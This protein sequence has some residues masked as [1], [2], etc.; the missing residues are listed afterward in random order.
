MLILKILLATYHNYTN[1]DES[2]FNDVKHNDAI[3]ASYKHTARHV[4]IVTN[5]IISMLRSLSAMI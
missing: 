3:L 4:S 1:Q 5:T 2:V